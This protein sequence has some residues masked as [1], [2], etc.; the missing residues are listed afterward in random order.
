MSG[1]N[2]KAFNILDLTL[3]S[4]KKNISNVRNGERN[5]IK[6]KVQ[7]FY[8]NQIIMCKELSSLHYF[9]LLPNTRSVDPHGPLA[10]LVIIRSVSSHLLLHNNL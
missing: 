8:S 10:T 2:A 3:A 7:M 5:A 9:N 6:R 4:Y 1:L